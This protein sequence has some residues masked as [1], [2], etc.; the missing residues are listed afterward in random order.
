MTKEEFA[1]LEREAEL[2]H[3]CWYS[4]NCRL[5]AAQEEVLQRVSAFCPTSCEDIL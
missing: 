1:K 4:E 5:T 3:V 2:G